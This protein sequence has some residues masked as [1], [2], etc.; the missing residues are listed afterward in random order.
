MQGGGLH[1]GARRLGPPLVVA[2]AVLLIVRAVPLIEAYGLKVLSL[3]SPLVVAAA[4]SAGLAA[5]GVLWALFARR[6]R[7]AAGIVAA[8]GAAAV[9]GS[10]NVPAC[11]AAAGVL[12]AIALLGDAALAL[13]LGRAPETDDFASAF[14]AG[15]AAAGLLVLG[16][17]EAG[18]LRPLTLAAAAL[19]LFAARARR[20]PALA[21]MLRGAWSVP[22]GGAPRGVEAA[23][24]AFAALVLLSA[25]IAAQSPDV[26]WDGLAYHLPEARDVARTGLV[27]P[28]PDLVP[29]SLLWRTYDAFL[30][31]GFFAGGEQVARYLQ[32]ACGLAVLAAACALARRIGA[33]RSGALVVLALAAFPTAML[34][35]H[36]TYVDWPCALFATACAAELA[37]ARGDAGRLRSA[38]FLLGSA[39]AAK[40]FAVT[41]VP[42]LAILAVRARPRPAAAAAAFALALA[43]LLPW[44]AWSEH[45]VGSWTEPFAPSPA[46]AASR[47][48][49]GHYFRTS[50][51]SGESR[52]APDPGA[53]LVRLA[54]LP[55]DL[56]FHSSR[57][58]ANGDGYN[59]IVVL[60]LAAGILGWSARAVG[61]FLLAAVPVLAAWSLLYLPSVR[62]LFPM[63]PMYAVF[64]S[65]G[66]RRLTRGFAGDSG[67]AA[68]AAILTAAAVLPVQ[69]GSSGVEWG[70]AL[71][72][73]SREQSL[74]ARL[75]DYPLWRSVSA[76]DRVVLLGENDRFYCPAGLAW[77]AE[78]LPVARW[79]RDPAA[80]RDGLRELGITRV[81]WREDRV[82][83]GALIDALNGGL[84]VEAR[85]GPAALYAVETQDPADRP[86][87]QT[88]ET[89]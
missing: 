63:Y 77:R 32:F 85:N 72:R 33:S 70:V 44:A 14:A 3:H 79:G 21:R 69:L 81:L 57:Y 47:L 10:G 83:A 42:A 40:V 73:V 7:A 13:L 49:S 27:R 88:G 43:P 16:L 46:A 84:R 53:A 18:A 61:L 55:Y 4:A 38:G 82:R 1:P 76:A 58:E 60:L 11:A 68:G 45:R 66:L 25:W 17:A 48:A 74:A 34:Q 41:A 50:P 35:L 39:V 19:I 71:G 12:A 64:A 30:A 26:S 28:L 24:L 20:I 65:E 9:V 52:R 29:H 62:Y 78:F 8:A 67:I 80:W 6:P 54:R 37:A 89:H 22:R 23:W 31:L 59:G 5:F 15:V 36:A 2:A 86:R 56:V 51:A 87:V 75:P